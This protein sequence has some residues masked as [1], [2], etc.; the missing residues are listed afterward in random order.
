M[1]WS[2]TY[3]LPTVLPLWKG[4][5]HSS[6]TRPEKAWQLGQHN[7]AVGG[8]GKQPRADNTK[9]TTMFTVCPERLRL[10][11]LPVS[12][13]WVTSSQEEKQHHPFSSVHCLWPYEIFI[14]HEAGDLLVHVAQM[15]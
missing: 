3:D 7:T 13:P 10:Q 11:S 4:P 14:L 15:T 2:I 12:A 9:V 1:W 5:L 8:T 6:Q